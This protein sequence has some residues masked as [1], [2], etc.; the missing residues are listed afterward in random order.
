MNISRLDFFAGCALAGLN[1][2]QGFDLNKTVNHL[3][4]EMSANQA[5]ELDEKLPREVVHHAQIKAIGEA[6]E[7]QMRKID[8]LRAA[9]QEIKKNIDLFSDGEKCP[10]AT[11]DGCLVIIQEIAARFCDDR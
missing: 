2:R 8:E 9:M 6:M 10:N 5:K 4:I 7:T 3:T 1:S 11:A